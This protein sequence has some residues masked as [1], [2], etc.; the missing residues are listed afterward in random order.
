MVFLSERNSVQV[1]LL[2]VDISVD[3]G[4]PTIKKG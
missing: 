2:V 4:D 3:D 1:L